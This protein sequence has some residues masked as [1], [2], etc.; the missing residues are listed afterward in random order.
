MKCTFDTSGA[1]EAPFAATSV[2]YDL[3]KLQQLSQVKP[4]VVKDRM[5]VAQLDYVYTFAVCSTTK[6]PANCLAADGTSRVDPYWAPAWQTNGTENAITVPDV[7]DRLC[8]YLGGNGEGQLST[9]SKFSVLDPKNP[10]D[11]GVRLTYSYGQHGSG[12]YKNQRREL[13]LNFKCSHACSGSQTCVEN[14]SDPSQNVMDESHH[15]KYEITIESEYACP[16][17]CGFGG[18]HSICGGHGVCGFDTDL[19]QARCF[20]NEG[21]SGSGC[22]AASEEEGLAG[23]GPILAL[24]IFVTIALV[25]L[26]A[27][28]VGLWRFVSERTVPLDGQAYARMDSDDFTPMRVDVQ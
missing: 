11:L 2:H 18:S 21:Y 26:V 28:V 17:E 5:Q 20:C 1:F 10:N 6:P 19:K 16:T 25:G 13:D 14:W 9:V 15:L 12:A 4:A 24:L 7:E 27:A 3:T 8:R 23:Y 22:D